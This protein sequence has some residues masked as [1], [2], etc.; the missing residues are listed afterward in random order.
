MTETKR[1]TFSDLPST[2]CERCDADPCKRKNEQP[3]SDLEASGRIVATG[4]LPCL[5]CGKPQK[6]YVAS[7][8]LTRH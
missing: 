1:D 3:I 4:E 7:K 2:G 5:K 8:F 6:V